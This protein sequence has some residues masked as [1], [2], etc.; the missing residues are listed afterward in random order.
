MVPHHTGLQPRNKIQGRQNV[1]ADALSRNVYDGAI[2]VASPIP[3]FSMEDLC[4]AQ[5]E[6]HL[7]KKV[8]YT[9]ESGDETQLPELP[10]LFLHFFVSQDGALCRYWAHKPVPIEQF[11]ILEKLVPTRLK[12]VHD[13]PISGHPGWDKTL[14]S[15]RKRYYWPKLRIDVVTCCAVCHLLSKQ[16]GGEGASPRTTISIARGALGHRFDRLTSVT[17]EPTWFTIPIGIC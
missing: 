13:V 12:L 16:G 11:V 2:A 1:V 6:H 9:L 14:G 17:S 5:R 10:N 7:W 8:I 3:N 15:A 4:S